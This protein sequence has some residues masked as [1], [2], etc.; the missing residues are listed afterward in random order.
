MQ[1]NLLARVTNQD[2]DSRQ[3]H[4]SIVLHGPK[5]VNEIVQN[6]YVTAQLIDKERRDPSS[7]SI[8]LFASY[9]VNGNVAN[10][11]RTVGSQADTNTFMNVVGSMART[12]WD[13]WNAGNS[14]KFNNFQAVELNDSGAF[15]AD[16]QLIMDVQKGYYTLDEANLRARHH[17]FIETISK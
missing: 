4:S 16:I 17:V 8:E 12:V 10:D 7:R 15:H 2:G 3:A 13:H 9:G 6:I 5:S 1:F 14:V 11:R